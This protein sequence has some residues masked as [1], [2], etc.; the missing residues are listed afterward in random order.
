MLS[1]FL[2]RVRAL[3]RRRAVEDDLAEELRFHLDQETER[4][5]ARG[6][7]RADAALAARRAF[8]NVTAMQEEA[9]ATYTFR[10]LEDLAQDL[11]YGVRGLLQN[12]T[13]T[14][15]VLLIVALGIGAN[16]ATFT[17]VDALILRPL[18]VPHPEQLVAIGN[19]ART[20]SMSSGGPNTGLASYPGL[21][22]PAR[23][24]PRR[25]GALRAGPHR[26]ARRGAAR[27][28][29]P[30]DVEHPRGRFVSGN[31]F[32]VLQVPA[33]LG[34]TLHR[35]RGS[36]AGRRPGR[37][38]QLRLLAA[39][40]RGRPGVDRPHHRHQRGAAHRRGRG[41]EGL[42]RRHRRAGARSLDPADDAAGAAAAHPAARRSGRVVAA[43]DGAPRTGCHGGARARRIRA[44][45]HADDPGPRD[46][47]EDAPGGLRAA[48][49]GA[50]RG[51]GTGIL[52][53]AQRLRGL[54]LDRHGG[55][56]ARAAAGLR[57][58]RQPDAGARCGAGARS[59]R[60]DGA[61]GGARA[62]DPP[63]AH[64]ERDPG[65]RRG[66]AGPGVRR[67]GERGP[68][69]S[70]ERGAAADPAGRAPRRSRAGLHRRVGAPH[71]PRLR[72]HTGAARH[73]GGAGG[74]PADAGARRHR[75]G[76][77]PRGLL[78]RQGPG[79]GAGGDIG[80]PPRRDRDARPEPPAPPGCRHRRGSGS[81]GDR[82]AWT[83]RAAGTR[84]AGSRL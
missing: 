28:R 69:E 47:L 27:G 59:Q 3:F 23:P 44:A 10:W 83:R 29:P 68:A 81:P 79:R 31:F 19:R 77:R 43:A 16:T 11:R 78:A 20:G 53:L 13:F 63:A 74:G 57:Q 76:P 45:R 6:M 67:L 9:R 39:A 17:L 71:R 73:A 2:I 12:K 46:R 62:R 14:A 24:E 7:S 22:G 42:L 75:R 60:A 37:G 70:R 56:R 38:R 15:A 82:H 1:G 50:G 32:E 54:A 58:R 21:C 72:P 52:L 49:A 61:G 55:G 34:R 51:G 40:A 36:G 84:T 5:A 30:G 26:A 48:R 8:G 65:R 35:R 80:D 33:A 66:R 41:A 18:P 4:H 25:D 64:G